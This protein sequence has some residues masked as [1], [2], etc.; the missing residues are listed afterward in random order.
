MTPKDPDDVRP[1]FDTGSQGDKPADG[2]FIV[3]PDGLPVDL[4]QIGGD[5]SGSVVAAVESSGADI[6]EAIQ[7]STNSDVVEAVDQA[8]A[9]IVGAIANSTN[10]D[11]VAAVDAAIDGIV[12][13]IEDSTNADVVAAV[14]AARADLVAAVESI[15]YTLPIGINRSA[16][17]DAAGASQQLMAA[18]PARRYAIITNMTGRPLW[19][20]EAGVAVVGGA[21]G[22][23]SVEL[24]H[25]SQGKIISQ[26]AVN[27]ACDT[28]GGLIAA[29][30]LQ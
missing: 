30:E 20:N 19:V 1:W 22:N 2:V 28:P 26:N 6:G 27:V 17:I 14:E 13:A 16:E 18:N 4:S 8:K 11:V 24:P 7:N 29:I 15:T 3:G 9:D 12:Q 23:A 10:A 25:G 5:S 21:A